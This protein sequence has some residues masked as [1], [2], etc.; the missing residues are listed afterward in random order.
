MCFSQSGSKLVSADSDQILI[1]NSIS[2]ELVD[3]AVRPVGRTGE[4]GLVRLQADVVDVKS[5]IPMKHTR[6]TRMHFLDGDRSMVSLEQCTEMKSIQSL[7]I[8][9]LEE[10]SGIKASAE[11]GLDQDPIHSMCT[12]LQGLTIY[13]C[14]NGELS[15]WTCHDKAFGSRFGSMARLWSI[16]CD[17]FDGVFVDVASAPSMGWVILPISHGKIL[18]LDD[19]GNKLRTVTRESAIITRVCMANDEC[20]LVGTSK[21]S[22]LWYNLPSMD[23]WR[24]IP[25][26]LALRDSVETAISASA[27]EL[28]GDS[29]GISGVRIS[30]LSSFAGLCMRY[31]ADQTVSVMDLSTG[32][33]CNASFGHINDVLCV[34]S[35]NSARTR[36]VCVY[37]GSLDETI[38]I[39]ELDGTKGVECSTTRFI[40]LPSNIHPSLTYRRGLSA[41]PEKINRGLGPLI[42]GGDQLLGAPSSMPVRPPAYVAETIVGVKGA[43]KAPGEALLT[44]QG[45]NTQA[46]KVEG[47]KPNGKNSIAVHSVAVDSMRRILACGTG[48]GR[49]MIYDLRTSKVLHSIDLCRSRVAGLAFV[50]GANYLVARSAQG[51]VWVLDSISGFRKSM[52]VQEPDKMRNSQSYVWPCHKVLVVEDTLVKDEAQLAST[53]QTQ[54]SIL[55]SFQVVTLMEPRTVAVYL[56]DAHQHSGTRTRAQ[57][58]ATIGV[59]ASPVDLALHASQQYIY[60]LSD[61]GRVQVKHLRSTGDAARGGLVSIP[62]QESDQGYVGACLALDPSGL[63]LAT[64]CTAR[65]L[66]ASTLCLW[67]AGTGQLVDCVRHLPAI[68]SVAFTSDNRGIVAGCHG[69]ALLQHL[70]PRSLGCR[71]LRSPQ[72]CFV[73]L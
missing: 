54:A 60:V 50:K 17:E 21:G 52:I 34:C 8:W 65:D 1:W 5:Q 66:S 70:H 62:T 7:R 10:R 37:T 36:G 19:Q 25:Y 64:I 29:A 46:D 63:Y 58:I 56:V 13:T 20:L 71:A 73:I 42:V 23:V 51:W 45:T 18:I 16:E 9:Q 59:E 61:K 11:H 68:R 35:A 26:D 40:D 12:Q 22:I 6:I 30:G 4:F 43:Q 67:E 55:L 2:W 53:V 41:A 31:T 15:A 47:Q 24:R 72:R 28:Q 32:N 49:C 38:G 69:G 27:V 44:Q 48:T 14:S 33:I 3:S 57:R 39:W